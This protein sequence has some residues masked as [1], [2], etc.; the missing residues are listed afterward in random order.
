MLFSSPS[1]QLPSGHDV[2]RQLR[3]IRA[4]RLPIGQELELH[5]QLERVLSELVPG[6]PVEREVHIAGSERIDFYLPRVKVGIECKVKGDVDT[7]M[8]QLA[9]YAAS[10]KIDSLVLVTGRLRHM[11]VFGGMTEIGLKPFTAIALGGQLL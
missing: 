8:R 7:V 2:V 9:R 3:G 11:P 4:Y 6:E 5:R 1:A 10:P